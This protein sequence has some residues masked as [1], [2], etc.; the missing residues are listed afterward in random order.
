M[1]KENEFFY[2]KFYSCEST[3]DDYE[4]GET[5]G[6]CSCWCGKDCPSHDMKFKSVKDAL[7]QVLREQFY[8]ETREWTDYFAQSGDE[9]DRGRF[10][11][12]VTVDE[13]NSEASE[14]D[15]AAWK[16]G[17]RTLYNCHITVQ[18]VVRSEREISD[19]DYG[20]IKLN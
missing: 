20:E 2:V 18:I 5:E 13:D 8:K 17:K 10:D 12:D 15:I 19:E 11:C 16:E 6:A 7:N 9:S 4:N 1:L 14:S 3:E